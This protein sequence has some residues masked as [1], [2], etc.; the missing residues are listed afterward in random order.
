MSMVGAIINMELKEIIRNKGF[1]TSLSSV[2]M[3]IGLLLFSSIKDLAVIAKLFMLYLPLVIGLTVGYGLSGRLVKEKT[4]GVIET[5]LCTPI[6]VWEIWLAKTLSISIISSLTT[7]IVSVI[8]PLLIGSPITSLYILY[9]MVVVPIFIT[10]ALGLLCLIYFY[11]GMKQIQAA[12]YIVFFIL[13]IT[14]FMIL[15]VQPLAELT[16]KTVSMIAVLSIIIILLSIYRVRYTDT[17][18]IVTTFE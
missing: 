1:L 7:I 3:F 15:K 18:R 5:L 16:L 11:L 13:F 14:L 4:Q 17:E 6:K 2:V 9:L 12:N 10:S 8:I